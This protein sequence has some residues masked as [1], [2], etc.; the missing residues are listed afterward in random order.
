MEMLPLEIFDP[1][2]AY[3]KESEYRK[4]ERFLGLLVASKKSILNAFSFPAS[5]CLKRM[6][7]QWKLSTENVTRAL[8]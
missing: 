3:V 4:S 7:S 8:A 6:K 5:K 2:I 1:I